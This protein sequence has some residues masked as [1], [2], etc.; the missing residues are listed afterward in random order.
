[1]NKKGTSLVEL[2]AVIVIMGI[3]ASISTVTVVTVIHR[4]RKNAAISSLN[5]I[6]RSAKALLVQVETG[7]YDENIIVVEEDYCYISLTVLIDTGSV[8]GVNYKPTENEI[9]YCY[10]YHSS[11]VI[12]S[13]NAPTNTIPAQT[14]VA[15]V[16]GVSITFDFTNDKFIFA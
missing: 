7:N 16:N 14:G 8:D 5:T 1:M 12:I 13:N 3:I 6:Y 2:I 9:Y 10:D 4:Q 11:W 15:L